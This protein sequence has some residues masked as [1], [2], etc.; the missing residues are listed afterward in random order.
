MKAFLDSVINNQALR[1]LLED[2]NF[3]LAL[4][5]LAVSVL[6][7]I[8]MFVA[9]KLRGK[10]RKTRR[11]AD[12]SEF[13]GKRSTVQSTQSFIGIKA[14]VDGIL[15]TTD[16][17][18]IKILEFYPINFLLKSAQDQETIISSFATFL[19]TCPA[20][21]QIKSVA[22]KTDVNKLIGIVERDLERETNE[23]CK[24]LLVEYMDFLRNVGAIE[25]V[26]RRFFI[27]FEDDAAVSDAKD[28][29]SIKQRLYI[30]ASDA[31]N[32][33]NACGNIYISGRS[34]DS[35]TLELL[36][37]LL[38]RREAET[39]TYSKHVNAVIQRYMEG[40][41]VNDIS[42][43]PYIPT[44]D[45]IAPKYI[46]VKDSKYIV[47]DGKYYSF[48]YL[49]SEG[50]HSLVYAGWMSPIIN[51]YEGIDVDIFFSRT[52]ASVV[53][54]KV[55]R[56]I[57]MNQSRVQDMDAVSSGADGMESTIG[58]GYYLRSGL[59]GGED[60]FYI[61]TLITVCTDSAE[62]LESRV[63]S[64][65]KWLT[66]QGFGVRV[67][68]YQQEQAFRS[69][70]PL[71]RL[72]KSLQAKSRRNCLTRDA[73]SAYPL[74]SYAMCDE[75]GV[76][77]GTNRENQSL[78]MLDNFNS[79][80][81]SNANMTLMGASGKGKTFALQCIALRM[82]MKGTQV[83]IIAPLKG[84]EFH[85]AC[86]AVG[87]QYIKISSGSPNCINIMEIRPRNTASGG[88][89]FSQNTY[90][91]LLAN[92]VQQVNIFF[93]LLVPD[94]SLEE[95]QVVD[96]AIMETYAR[97]GITLDNK[98]L[99]D[100][101]RP[102]RYK[103]MPVLGDVYDTMESIPEAK[104]VRTILRTFVH[105]SSKTFNQQTNVDLSNKYI[106]LDISELTKETLLI[107]MFI[108]LDY[109]WD[110][111]KQDIISKKTIIL[112]ELWKLI[113][114]GS[115]RMVAEYVLEI[116]KII[117]GYG[118]S[119]ICATQDLNDFFAL[120]NGEFGRGIINASSIKMVFGLENEEAARVQECLNLTDKEAKAVREFNRGSA[121]I[122]T[123]GNNV[124]VDFKASD[125]ERKLIT[126]DRTELALL[127]Q[128]LNGE[129]QT[130]ETQML[131]DIMA[132]ERG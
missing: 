35:T 57:R 89:L 101:K 92:K 73:A 25:G 56:N 21:I 67:C 24:I 87:G 95:R 110:K 32:T 98:S 72:D 13:K 102:G 82:R 11:E 12:P 117:R 69:A 121:L 9:K 20:K 132:R 126:T 107:G 116:F 61:S 106:V 114:Q 34:Q 127:W 47:V 99:L 36:Y 16:N 79:T 71:C 8:G 112:D 55:I 6:I 108:A 44:S 54:E 70:L 45:M 19:R 66:S 15:V 38:N 113:G 33:I 2:H 125:L 88:D 62:E 42:K 85:R 109:V 80:I 58:A 83:F 23:Y 84:H 59:M 76:L 48:L 40:Y 77:L 17:R 50:Y 28:F 60:F 115:N 39:V 51:A 64:I 18:Y 123:N 31:I 97:K 111:A 78:V 46:A 124:I 122:S 68:L 4:L 130:P 10:R 128:E 52:D 119:A 37:V 5:L 104:R 1:A 129:F 96:A 41:G 74:T 43:V 91:S 26:S 7:L 30:A 22:T 75:E 65:R 100:P 131:K 81:Y 27:I 90:D 94:M 105:G 53:L 63:E 120:N 49:T 93:S 103:E 3:R 86:L 118:G 29:E 14:V